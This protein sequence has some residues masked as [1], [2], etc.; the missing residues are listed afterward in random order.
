MRSPADL[1]HAAEALE[2][3]YRSQLALR[4]SREEA[5]KRGARRFPPDVALER[6]RSFRRLAR[7]FPGALRELE[8]SPATLLAERAAAAGE[9]AQALREGR[10]AP[11]AEWLQP[12]AD[13]HRSLRWALSLKRWI[14]KRQPRSRR[15][16]PETLS[17]FL[18]RSR[19]LQGAR[20][21]FA[22]RL[23]SRPEEAAALL[24]ELW[25][26]R[27]DRWLWNRLSE[28]YGQTVP[29]L[30]ALLFPFDREPGQQ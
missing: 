15:L 30:Q 27:L 28:E 13:Y 8:R 11:E 23:P 24:A 9:L 7:E 10:A 21:P 29:A 20:A 2:R 22:Q 14:A 25:E 6:R 1:L 19:R 5:E 3:K 18:L 26:G 4:T 12:M 17:A 16:E